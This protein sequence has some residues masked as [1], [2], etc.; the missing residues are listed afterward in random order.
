[1]HAAFFVYSCL[2]YS[3]I[4]SI[5]NYI[6]IKEVREMEIIMLLA[7]VVIVACVAFRKI[8]KKLG[9]PMLFAFIILGML[10]GSDGLFKIPFE[11]FEFAQQI[12]SIALIFI[13]FYGGFGT[14]WSLAKPVAA[15]ALTLSSLGTILTALIVGVFCHFVLKIELLESF[16]IGSVISST[17]AASVFSILRSKRLNLKNGTASLLEL[18]SGSNDPFSYML[19]VI[20]L[21]LMNMNTTG[22]KFVLLILAQLF[23]GAIFG[24][25]IAFGAGYVLKRF[26]FSDGFDAVFLVAVAMLSYVLPTLVGG[27]GYLSVYI[28]GIILGNKKLPNKRSLAHFFDGITGLM[29]MLLFFILGLLAFPSHLPS[30]APYALAIALFL[31]FVARPLAVFFLSIPF[32]CNINQILLVSWAGMRGAASI[33]FAILTVIDPAYTQ[34][35][36]FHIVF[37]IVLFSILVQGSLIPLVSQKLDMTDSDS[38]VMKTFNDYVEEYPVKYVQFTIPENSDWEGKKVSELSLPPDLLLV[39]VVRGNNKYI[40]RGNTVIHIGDTLILSGKE[41]EHI[42]GV[43]LYEKTLQSGDEWIDKTV[44]EI[45]TD[46]TL[47]VLIKRGNLTL[48]P[49]GNTKLCKND[50]LVINEITAEEE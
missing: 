48:I 20:V 39:L 38:D 49:R 46:D 10:F 43:N 37:F 30:I 7:A 42:D 23:F 33:V 41:S 15:Y 2:N 50:V 35:D 14:K 16:L 1:M 45:S 31:T 13:M 47:L 24:V 29:Q 28:T 27:N 36:I 25:A 22:G 34:N 17:D 19:T 21:S 9:V 11:N 4:Y 8:S 26:K 3:V 12:C 44:T 40:P 18:E 32:K 6:S 5:M